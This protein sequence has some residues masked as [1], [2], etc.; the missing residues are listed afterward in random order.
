MGGGYKTNNNNILKRCL[1]V[2]GG[3][4]CVLD[5]NLK[6][7]FFLLSLFSV[8]KKEK[9]LFRGLKVV[10]FSFLFFLCE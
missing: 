5:Y 4:Y 9:K 6:P 3:V 2:S 7:L 1:C 8:P 10:I